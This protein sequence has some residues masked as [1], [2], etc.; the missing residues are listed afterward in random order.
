MSNSLSLPSPHI[1]LIPSFEKSLGAAALAAANANASD[2]TTD[3]DAPSD[4]DA[5]PATMPLST[6][7]SPQALMAYCEAQL[8]SLDTQMNTIFSQEQKN[9]QLTS[10]VNN[11]AS[12][13][14]DIPAP[15]GTNTTTPLLPST[16]EEVTAAYQ[17]AINQA[18]EL[19]DT[20]LADSLTTDQAAWAAD[21]SASGG[22]CI[23]ATDMS[24]LTTNLKNYVSDLNSDSQLTMINLQQLM[25]QRETAVQ[26]T[27]NLVQSLGDQA[28]DVAKNIGQ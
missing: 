4:V 23:S 27:T 17:T 8:D 26:L 3:V 28:N 21:V 24:Q 6:S 5:P 18:N 1:G 14:N 10:V 25:S 7:L 9:N 11:L 19:G 13:L 2:G 15:S 20:A 22:N 16:S 12:T